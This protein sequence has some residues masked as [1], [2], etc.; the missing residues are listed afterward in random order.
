MH[1]RFRELILAVSDG[2]Q[3][4]PEEQKHLRQ[5]MKEWREI[6][7]EGECPR[8]GSCPFSW[9]EDWISFYGYVHLEELIE[10][11]KLPLKGIPLKPGLDALDATWARRPGDFRP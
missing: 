9:P 11:I 3:L 8:R 5:M 7:C 4:S 2:R 1:I 6:E 10:H